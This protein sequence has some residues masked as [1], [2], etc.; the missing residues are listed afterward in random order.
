M[1]FL[2]GC[3]SRSYLY[4]LRSRVRGLPSRKPR[5]FLAASAS[6]VR[7]E[8][9]VASFWATAAKM[10]SVDSAAGKSTAWKRT[11]LS[12]S[13][14][15]KATLRASRSR[16]GTRST[17]AFCQACAMAACIGPAVFAAAFNLGKRSDQ[18]RF[19]PEEIAHRSLLGFEAQAGLALVGGAHAV[20]GDIASS[21][22]YHVSN[23]FRQRNGL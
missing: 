15:K 21:R 19:G 14:T 12:M 4:S 7:V 18:Y 13:A 2:V 10:C 20:V 11:R 5:A 16:L 17:A 3:G 22:S 9:A 1:N 8:M 6:R 23:G